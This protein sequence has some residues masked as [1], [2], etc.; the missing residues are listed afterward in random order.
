MDQLDPHLEILLQEFTRV[1]PETGLKQEDW[2]GLYEICL[3]AQEH[4][5]APTDR[6]IRDYLVSHGCSLQKAT[7]LSNQ[8]GHLINI[9]KLR[10]ERKN[11]SIGE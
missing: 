4:D 3:F 10:D 5:V 1:C 11:G 6:T 9:L 8:Y 2:R 7:F